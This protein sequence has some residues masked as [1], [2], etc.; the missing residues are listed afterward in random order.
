M[1]AG[2]ST[3]WDGKKGR[4]Q[5]EEEKRFA[6]V[7]ENGTFTKEQYEDFKAKNGNEYFTVELKYRDP[8]TVKNNLC[9]ALMS[10]NNPPM[11][12]NSDELPTDEKD[13]QFFV[14]EMTNKPDKK[15]PDIFKKIERKIGHYVRTVLKDEFDRIQDEGISDGCRY[16]IPVPITPEEEQ[17]FQMNQTQTSIRADDA[18]LE[19]LNIIEDRRNWSNWSR[20]LINTIC[21][22]TIPVFL[23]RKAGGNLDAVRKELQRRGVLRRGES[24]VISIGGKKHRC[25]HIQNVPDELKG[26]IKLEDD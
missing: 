20:G 2:L 24:E 7:D 3:K 4:F 6:Y 13:N 10:N 12:V 26:H 23:L 18:I 5:P 8:K 1:W 9:L 15:D 19:I 16:G 21:K 22:G 25:Y 17:M 11:Y 14:L